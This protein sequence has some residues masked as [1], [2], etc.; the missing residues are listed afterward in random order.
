MKKNFLLSTIMLFVGLFPIS[1]NT[2]RASIPDDDNP[3]TEK[4]KH[5]GDEGTSARVQTSLN[6]NSGILTVTFLDDI[7]DVSIV[8]YKNTAM[9]EY[10]EEGD[11][12][13]YD[14]FLF[15][16][17]THGSGTYLVV[18]KSDDMIIY[19]NTQEF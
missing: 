13:T 3:V 12:Y 2:M 8:I 18:I 16:L 14:S 19:T 15:N 1:T 7:E 5:H 4:D 10:E 9:V 11:V 6:Y 17:S